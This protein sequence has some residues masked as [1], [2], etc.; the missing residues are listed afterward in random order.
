MHMPSHHSFI[1]CNSVGVA[2]FTAGQR[3]PL[4]NVRTFP[5]AREAHTLSHLSPGPYRRHP[6]RPWQA[7]RAFT[8]LLWLCLSQSLHRHRILQDLARGDWLLSR[9]TCS[10]FVA[11]ACWNVVPFYCPTAVARAGTPRRVDPLVTTWS[12]VVSPFAPC[13]GAAVSAGGMCSGEDLVFAVLQGTDSEARGLCARPTCSGPIANAAELT[14][15]CEIPLFS[16]Q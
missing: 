11:L 12:R 14:V 13:D 1:V 5:A 10:R 8:L 3:S 7:R 15:F 9:S 4:C 2:A 6:H 16:F